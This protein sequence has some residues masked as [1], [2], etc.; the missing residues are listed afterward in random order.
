VDEFDQ[1]RITLQQ[2]EIARDLLLSGDEAGCRVSLIVLDTVAEAILYRIVQTEFER[3][4]F[5]RAFVPERYPPKTRRQIE[6]VFAE[7]LEAVAK[8][9]RL[10]TSVVT[11]ILI[12]HGYRNAAYHRDTHNPVVLPLLARVALL[13]VAD[14]FARTRGGIVIGAAGGYQQ[15]LSWL[16]QYGFDNTF[17]EFN[18]AARSVGRQLKSR[19]R[20]AL[21]VLINGFVV[22]LTSRIAA[23]RQ[24]LTDKLPSPSEQETNR[25]LKW[26]EFRHAHPDLESKLSVEY[27][28]L[29]YKIAAGS[30]ADVTR[31]EYVAA[32]ETFRASYRSA[33]DRFEQRCTCAALASIEAAIPELQVSRNYRRALERY[34]ALDEQVTTFEQ[35]TAAAHRQFEHDMEMESDMRRGK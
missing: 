25:I 5:T 9:R 27:R 4:D 1:F 31:D 12:L 26:F 32:E 20:P 33:H 16:E 7:K 13:A 23:V 8:A 22:D 30:G 29:N 17:L 15:P 2:L 19:V 21:Q 3:D 34:A 35:I 28:T 24:V 11:T 10:P 14:L 18:V 6:R